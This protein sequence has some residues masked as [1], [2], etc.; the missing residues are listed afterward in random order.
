MLHDVH[1]HRYALH[2]VDHDERLRTPPRRA[3]GLDLG[4][5]ELRGALVA[6]AQ[7][8]LHQI[9]GQRGFEP[10]D[11]RGLAGLPLGAHGPRSPWGFEG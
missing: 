3:E 9:E 1:Q 2:F 4:G 7:L 5:Q 6:L 10:R 8:G 11:Q